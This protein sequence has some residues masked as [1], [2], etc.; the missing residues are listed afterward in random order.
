MPNHICILC[1]KVFNRKSNYDYHVENKKKPCIPTIK[2][3]PPESA[4]NIDMLI[5]DEILT[6]D[7][8][9]I[10][11]LKESLVN[12]NNYV[13]V[14][15]DKT[16]TRVDSLKKHVNGRCKLQQNNDEFEKLKKN[17]EIIINN[18]LN[19]EKEIVNFKKEIVELKKEIVE[20]KNIN[21]VED[22]T[23]DKNN[24]NKV[25]D[26]NKI[27]NE[28]SS[29]KSKG[30][31]K[32]KNIPQTLRYAVWEKYFG[33]NNENKCLC[34]KNATIAIT[35]FDCGHIVSNKAGG[36]IHIDN[37]KPICKTCNSSMGT[38]N[39]NEF[40]QRYGL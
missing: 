34:C 14:Y 4:N 8:V 26:K 2:N 32:R 33:K 37:L 39:M 24:E 22:V 18:N 9:L 29:H 28:N 15:C 11:E 23:S 31:T 7:N 10:E 30:Q 40:I 36:K 19:L 1:N 6:K 20:L 13:C 3:D 17:M 5:K 16:F 27:N 38:T 25:I 12:T 21:I 35:N